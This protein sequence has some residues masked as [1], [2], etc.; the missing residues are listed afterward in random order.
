MMPV[1][2]GDKACAIV[3]SVMRLLSVLGSNIRSHTIPVTEKK[4][5]QL[6]TKSLHAFSISKKN[7]NNS[8]AQSTLKVARARA[9]REDII[10]KCT[11]G[12]A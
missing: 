12:S 2:T 7:N 1:D 5:S 9:C 11:G 3:W 8:H 10:V 6:K 4:N